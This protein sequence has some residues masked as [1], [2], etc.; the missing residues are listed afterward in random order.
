MLPPIQIAIHLNAPVKCARVDCPNTIVDTKSAVFVARHI[1][2]VA[3][4]CPDCYLQTWRWQLQ[5]QD[6]VRTREDFLEELGYYP[7]TD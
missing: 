6:P 4:C 7:P 3:Y 1:L 5:S 2:V